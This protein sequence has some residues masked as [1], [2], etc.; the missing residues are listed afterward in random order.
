MKLKLLFVVVIF[1]AIVTIIAVN[2]QSS[3]EETITESDKVLFSATGAYIYPVLPGTKEWIDLGSLEKRIEACKVPDEILASMSTPALV[4]TV[5]TYPFFSALYSFDKIEWGL[6]SLNKKF[7]GLQ[8][9]LKRKDA[10]ECTL[11]MINKICPGYYEIDNSDWNIVEPIL[12]EKNKTNYGL[13]ELKNADWIIRIINL[14]ITADGNRSYS[15]YIMTPASSMV[16]AVQGYT[17]NEHFIHFYDVDD[18]NLYYVNKHP[19]AFLIDN[20]TA[21][22]N[23]HSYAW[24]NQSTSNNIWIDYNQYSTNDVRLFMTDGS[25]IQKSGPAPGRIAV[26]K[27]SAGEPT[28]SARVVYQNQFNNL[29]YVTSKWHAY[30]LFYHELTDCEYY[31]NDTNITYW[32]INPDYVVITSINDSDT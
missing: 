18:V 7:G 10:Y 15:I 12:K 26:Y 1:L 5:I 3:L 24:Y 14:Q 4:E 11:D 30:G 13:I 21:A 16:S 27:N 23:C 8:E 19:S 20:G 25:Y 28:H 6:E 2:K 29:I 32:E 22:Y 31:D 9:L 17:Y